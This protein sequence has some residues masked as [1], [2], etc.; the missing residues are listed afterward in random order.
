M[1]AIA[2][3]GELLACV[4]NALLVRIDGVGKGAAHDL[5]SR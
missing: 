3:A 2:R 4:P 5:L 1:G